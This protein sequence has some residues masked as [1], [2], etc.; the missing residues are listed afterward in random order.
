MPVSEYKKELD[1]IIEL[2]SNI[3]SAAIIEN[4]GNILALSNNWNISDKIE[5]II[6][7]WDS[8]D[9][10]SFT[11]LGDK[12]IIIYKS[13]ESFI[14]INK[15]SSNKSIIGFKYDERIIFC[16]I[17]GKGNT[18]LIF[19]GILKELNKFSSK[20]PYIK[21]DSKFGKK[22]KIK[23]T[24]PK[25]LL[26]NTQNLKKLGLLK[27]GLSFDEAKVYLALLS[28]GEQGEKV[29]NL[30]KELDIKRTTIYRIIDRLIEN[31][32][33]EKISESPQGVS[34]FAAR[35]LD[36][37]FDE[38]IN[39]KEEELR[40]LK[41]MKY[42]L[43]ETIENGWTGLS[44]LRKESQ[45]LGDK[46][47]TYESMDIIGMEKDC[48]LIIFDYEE[49]V[50]ETVVLK[51]ALQLVN[52]KM[53][54]EIKSQKNKDLE[55]IKIIDTKFQEYY[56]ATI[57]IKFKKDSEIAK[58]VGEDWIVALKQVAIPI[59]DKIYVIWGSEE[60]FPVLMS[61]ILRLS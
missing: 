54:Y 30:N 36:A 14:A 59:G 1:F 13:L 51:G 16:Q 6:H 57:H 2:D 55:D 50:S 31:N 43:G 20:K 7:S 41:S 34:I 44:K 12:Y 17:K 61:I 33:V 23:W 18:N 5:E 28:K 47:I 40:I 35:S 39:Q 25:I 52:E 15:T 19:T 9:K 49:S 53:M 26:D 46:A 60:K 29:G 24:T 58:N 48:G 22:G 42:I 21:E 4:D 45:K 27:V 32:W 10:R 56:G 8:E 3:L 37:Q 38:I 11:L